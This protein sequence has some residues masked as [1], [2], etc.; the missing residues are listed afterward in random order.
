MNFHLICTLVLNEI[1]LRMRRL[2]TVVTMLAVIVL[3]WMM[4][5]DP[6]TGNTLMSINHARVLY[7]SST[8][9]LG[10]ASLA[11][12]LLGLAGFYLVRGRIAEDLRS[13]SGSVIAATP[14]GNA[15]F[16]CCR[17]LGGTLYLLTLILALLGA[18][19]VCHLLRGEAPIEL[20]IYLQ[21]YV[22]LLVPMALFCASCAILFDSFSPLMGKTGDVIFFFIWMGQLVLMAKIDGSVAGRID[23]AMYFDFIGLATAMANLKAY[24]DTTY[25]SLGTASFDP[26]L[27]AI[28]LPASLWSL[29]VMTIRA[30]S[31]LL[32][33]MPLVP[34]IMLFHRFS[35]D[36]VRMVRARQR[37]SPLGYLNQWLRPFARLAQPLF[38][39]AQAL[40]GMPGQVAADMALTVASAPVAGLALLLIPF[41]SLFLPATSLPGLL[42]L[43][44]AIW[45]I[46]ISDIST[47]DEQ[48]T[49]A[50]MTGSAA[51]GASLAYIRHLAASAGIGFMLT[52]VI[53]LRWLVHEPVRAA[54]VISGI[55]SLSAVASLLGRLS[56]TSRTFMSLF[57]FALYV[58]VNATHISMLDAFGFNG[59]ASLQSISMQI[60]IAVAAGCAGILQQPVKTWA[61][62]R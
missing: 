5:P 32:A 61:M 8:M 51:G 54:A 16:L 26:A 55:I 33:I 3:A 53:A 52:G 59:V 31:A 36:R 38:R 41:L 60:L 42:M 23:P 13:G 4:I 56:G 40:S 12:L 28:T 22:L 35:P 48:T 2:S 47:R 50:D 25:L 49:T 21:T 1:R 27:S 19:L 17:A 9:A 46:L 7:T 58:A 30:I 45:G 37:R 44:V 14:V 34:A 11:S 24:V 43:T 15:M 20:G 39:L 18:M 6:G 62:G 10:S 57:L 29:K